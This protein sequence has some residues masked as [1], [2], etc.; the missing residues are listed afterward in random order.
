M[1]RDLPERLAAVRARVAERQSRRGW[2]HAV[3]I[4]AVTKGWGP[5]AVRAAR[6][7]GLADVGENR[8]QEAMAK[9]DATSELGLTWHLV[10]HLQSNKA[11]QAVTRFALIHSVDAIRLGAAL[12]READKRGSG[13]RVGVLLQVN[14]AREPQKFG[15]AP[16]EAP[17]LAADLAARSHLELRGLMAMAPFEADEAEQRRVFGGLRALRDRLAAQGLAVEELSMGMSQ[18]YEV[19]VEEGAT[20]LR[21]GT[22]LFGERPT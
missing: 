20:I 3:R 2:T 15:C 8:V 11:R 14:V 16:D 10:G 7:A 18:D 17:A 6:A 13:S 5:E 4:V 1:F 12:E 19:A 22:V 9:L 21:L